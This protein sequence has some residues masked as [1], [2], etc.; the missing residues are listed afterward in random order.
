MDK[1]GGKSYFGSK[2][3]SIIERDHDTI[4]K[5]ETTILPLHDFQVNLSEKIKWFTEIGDTLEQ[6]QKVMM[7]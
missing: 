2:L 6:N 7:Q 4:R 3:H 1:K 5:F